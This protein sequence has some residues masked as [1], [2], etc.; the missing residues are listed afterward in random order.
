M[1]DANPIL[2]RLR[3]FIRCTIYFLNYAVKMHCNLQFRD[4][5]EEI[6]HNDFN[7]CNGLQ[8]KILTDEV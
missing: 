7:M 3:L 5:V 1:Y 2:C 6:G 8:I 4:K